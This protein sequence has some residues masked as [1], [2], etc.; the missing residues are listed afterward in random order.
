ML[1]V[2]MDDED[3][4]DQMRSMIDPQTAEVPLDESSAEMLQ[5][6]RRRKHQLNARKYVNAS[7]LPL[8]RAK[9]EP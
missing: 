1:D 2:L 4:D 3:E 5:L 7:S 9:K 6:R 8:T